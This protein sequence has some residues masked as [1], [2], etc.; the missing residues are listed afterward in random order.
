MRHPPIEQVLES[1]L[2]GVQLRVEIV[3]DLRYCGAWLER[4]PATR[5]GAFHLIG[6]GRCVIEAPALGGALVL[7][8]GDLVMFPHGSGHLLRAVDACAPAA[9]ADPGYT[10][11]L[12]GE[13]AFLIGA[14]NPVLR[15]LPDCLI[16]R[17]RDGGAAFAHLAALLVDT[18]RRGGL[19]R[20]VMLNTLAASLFILAV[21]EYATQNAQP[22]GLFAGLAD[23]RIARVLQA[24]HTRPDEDWSM[25][26]LADLAGMSRSAFAERFTTLLDTPP[27]QYLA[28]WRV[29]QAWQLLKNP[30]LSVAAIA[31]QLGY[32]S[33]PAFRKLF[34]RLTGIGP[35]KV[36]AGGEDLD[37]P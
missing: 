10:S 29:S 1:A 25:A 9:D 34:K 35:G 2:N 33:E 22:R 17:A 27:M 4:E 24:I 7:E 36:R 19:G 31:E 23:P 13:F 28:Q 20:Q 15:A 37:A 14:H 6:E 8:A 32:K 21:C 5:H 12:C 26:R 16:V 18:S 3:D 11:M 30:R